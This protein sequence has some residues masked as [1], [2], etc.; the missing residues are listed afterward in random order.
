MGWNLHD[1]FGF[2]REMLFD[3]IVAE[4]EDLE[5]IR[6]RRLSSLSLSEVVD[7]LAIREGLL[8]VLVVE[9]DDCVSVWERFAFDA[10][11]KNDLFFT[12]LVDSL[13][14]SVMTYILLDYLLVLKGFAVILFRKSETEVF[15]LVRSS[16][17]L[18]SST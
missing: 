18:A 9:V 4:F 2:I 3:L 14:L 15:F 1:F 7:D 6:E 12:V 8:D 11:V 16:G 17:S 5:L 13:D 10:V